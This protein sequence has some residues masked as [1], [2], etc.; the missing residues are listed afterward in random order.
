MVKAIETKYNGYR[1]RSRLEARWAVFFDALEVQWEY[2][3][4]GFE[5]STGKRYLPDFWLPDNNLWV[6][7]KGDQPDFHYTS[8]LE[9]FCDSIDQPLLLAV[10]LPSNY[11]TQL[12]CWDVGDSSAGGPT[13]WQV[14]IAAIQRGEL[15]FGSTDLRAHRTLYADGL[16]E[17]EI[18][19]LR[20]AEVEVLPLVW[21]AADKAKSARFEFGESG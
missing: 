20:L 18:E 9:N 6:E 7:I 21:K 10:G 2:E 3:K 13:G 15:R 14:H 11:N 17:K 4:E 12:L 5:L 1:F 19:V 16:F 8:M